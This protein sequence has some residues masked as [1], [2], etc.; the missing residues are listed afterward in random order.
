MADIEIISPGAFASVRVGLEPNERF[1]S[2]AGAMVR[3]TSNVEVDVTTRPKGSKSGGLLGGLKRLFSGDSFF[4]ST[5][6]AEGSAGEVVLA[7]VMPGDCY[8]VELDGSTKWLCAGG[9]YIASGE[10]VTLDTQFQ[11]F[12]GFVSGENMFFRECAGTGPLVVNAFGKIREVEI[13]GDY[14]IDTG[15]VVA[16]E[17]GIGYTITKAGSS[18][19]ASF[20]AGEGFVM[21]FSGKGKVLVQSHNPTEFGKAVGPKLPPRRA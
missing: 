8:V 21:N 19:L 15:H 13:D 1:I 2:D 7:P 5:Y 16:F 3:M 11:G 12:K 14:I 20:L 10:D 18:W 17:L 4:M 6:H 9:S